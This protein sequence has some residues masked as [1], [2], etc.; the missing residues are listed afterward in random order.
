MQLSASAAIRIQVHQRTPWRKG[1]NVSKNN[2]RCMTRGM[3]A[4]ALGGLAGAW[5]MNRFWELQSKYQQQRQS[6]AEPQREQQGQNNRARDNPTVKVAEAISTTLLRHPLDS[7]KKQPAGTAVHYAF[8]AVVGSVYGALSELSPLVTRG[9]GTSYASFVWL[10]GD[11][12]AVPALKLSPPL[13]ESSLSQ[14]LNGLAAH[15]LFGLTS[16]A[17]RRTARAVW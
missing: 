12:I 8:G 15:L 2:E 1:R 9:F 4:G 3:L 7:N 13:A 11:E 17:V 10:G 14:N 6:P 5:M 16:E